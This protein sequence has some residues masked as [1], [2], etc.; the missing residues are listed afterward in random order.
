MVER[1]RYRTIT[2]SDQLLPSWQQVF[3]DS[4]AFWQTRVSRGYPCIVYLHKSS[5]DLAKNLIRPRAPNAHQGVVVHGDISLKN[6]LCIR[7]NGTGMSKFIFSIIKAF[8]RMKTLPLMA[9]ELLRN[10]GFLGEVPQQYDH[11]LE[12]FA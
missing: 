9:V 11:E 2:C 5:S 8:C 10:V 12:S 1:V 7:G 6:L 4:R 3:G